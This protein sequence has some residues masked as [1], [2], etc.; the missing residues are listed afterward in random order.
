MTGRLIIALGMVILLLSIPA[1]G[2]EWSDITPVQGRWSKLYFDYQQPGGPGTV[3]TFYCLNDWVVNRD[4]GCDKGGI[5]CD[6]TGDVT[7]CE[8]NL[9]YFMSGSQLYTITIYKNSATI[10]PSIAG[11]EGKFSWNPLTQ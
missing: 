6:S 5:V 9:Y 11:F 8:A 2:Q 7:V 4:D 10:D 1:L 3:G